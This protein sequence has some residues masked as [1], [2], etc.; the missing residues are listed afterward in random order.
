MAAVTIC[1]DFGAK[2][3]KICHG[4]HFFPYMPWSNGTGCLDLSFLMLRFKPAFSLHLD[5]HQE[6]ISSSLSAFSDI[7]CIS[8]V[9]N[10]SPGN[11]DS[12]L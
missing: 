2:E 5:P 11:L 9:L 3:K 7:I 6:A 1:S 4:F 12:S 8:D 10:N